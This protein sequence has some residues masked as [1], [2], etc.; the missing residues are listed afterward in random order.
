[1]QPGA[2]AFPA[3][4]GMNTGNGARPCACVPPAARQITGRNRTK[5]GSGRNLSLRHGPSGVACNKCR[6]CL[7]NLPDL[8]RPSVNVRFAPKAT[9]LVRCR[10]W[11]R[12]AISGHMRRSKRHRYSITSSAI[13]RSVGGT[14]TPSALAVFRLMISSNFVGRRPAGRPPSRH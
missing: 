1:V 3:S 14:V 8:C 10:E 9:E 12:R 13:L 6:A 11:T 2:D 5:T 7:G 4:Y